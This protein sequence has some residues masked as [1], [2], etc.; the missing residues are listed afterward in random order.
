MELVDDDIHPETQS[1]S[2]LP[3]TPMGM[4]VELLLAGVG[5]AVIIESVVVIWCLQHHEEK[6]VNDPEWQNHL[7]AW[8]VCCDC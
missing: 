7:E 4:K 1:L 3:W 5:K 6:G 2:E 8:L